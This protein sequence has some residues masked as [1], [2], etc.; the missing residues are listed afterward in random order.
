MPAEAPSA[1]AAIEAPPPPP[2]PT[3]EI[4]VTPATVDTGPKAPPPK[5]GSAQ[6]RMFEKL[7]S[8]AKP[9]FFETPDAPATPEQSP[10]TA[11]SPNGDNSAESPAPSGTA[12]SPTPEG[13]TTD[14]KSAPAKEGKKNPWKLVDEYKA[15]ATRAESELLESKKLGGDPAKIQEF[16]TTIQNLQKQNEDLEKEIR[17]T[18]YAK[19]SEFKSKYQEPYEKAWARAVKELSEVTI[20]DPGT[21]QERAASLADLADIVQLPLGKA[22]AAAESVFGPFAD[23]VMAYRKE[24]IGLYEAQETALK[25]ARDTSIKRDKDFTQAQQKAMGESA[26]VI[27]CHLGKSQPGVP[28]K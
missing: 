19:S 4:H 20:T 27:K 8:R 13:A 17:F 3:S 10:S 28:R 2:A 25:E 1:P 14:P 11:E 22:R 15:R 21:N 18:N 5:K 26:A 7:R 16:Q 12:N 6:E 24:I 9:Q 23:D